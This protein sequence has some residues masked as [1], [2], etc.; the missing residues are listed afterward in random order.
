MLYLDNSSTT[1][2]Y[3]DVLN[4]YEQTSRRYFG[5]PSSLHRYGA[6]TEQLLQAAKQQIKRAMGLKN[7]DIVFTSGATEAN[8][9]AL[10]GAALSKIKAGKH[11]IATSIEHPS[12]TESLE[13]LQELFGFDVTYLSVNE[14]GFV[15]IEELKQSIRPDTVLVSMMHVNNEVGSVQPVEEAGEMLKEHPN[16]LFHVDYVQGIYKV[17]L[18]I[19]T[20]G[21][22]L[23]SISGHKI[24][25]LKGTGAL[26]VKEGTRLI[27]LITG[28]SQQKG[29]RAGTEHTAGAVSLAKAINLAAADFETRLGTMAAAKELFMKRLSETEGVVVSTPQM[30][31]APHIINFSVPGI[32]AE[33]LLHMLEEQHIFVST[34]SACSAKENKP[35]K[36][37]LQMGKGEQVAGSSIRIS[38]HYSQ[39]SEVAEPFMDALVPGIKKLKKMM[40]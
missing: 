13:Q 38:L 32:K 12:V 21:I 1:K 31:S 2:P 7:Y 14:D 6:E 19:E 40:R 16:I 24:H 27:P 23:C 35:S 33:V 37:L 11:I 10:K 15:S 29:I 8:N 30:N 22:D 28:G 4:T 20:S 34:T 9:L 26:I 5:N 25:G 18:A 3:D 39:T 36:V 17:P